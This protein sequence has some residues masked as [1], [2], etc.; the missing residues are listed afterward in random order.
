MN[1][2]AAMARSGLE[3]AGLRLSV[4]A[5]AVANLL[6]PGFQPSEVSAAELPGGGVRASVGPGSDPGAARADRALL[7]GSGTDLARELLAQARG[8]HLYR[9]N[10]A[11]L[12][13]ADALDE[14]ALELKR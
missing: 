3:A 7:A 5:H 1:T 11:V 6:T 9:A 2:L 14:A 10:L 13:T 4:S 8:V 12:R